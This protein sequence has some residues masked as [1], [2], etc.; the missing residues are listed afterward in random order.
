MPLRHGDRFLVNMLLVNLW[1]TLTDIGGKIIVM[2]IFR[3]SCFVDFSDLC[4][5]VR[6]EHGELTKMLIN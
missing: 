5:R 4:A 1:A 6:A 3:E 2:Q